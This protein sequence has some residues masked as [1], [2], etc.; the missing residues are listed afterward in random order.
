MTGEDHRLTAPL[1]NS[2]LVT[3]QEWPVAAGRA[4]QDGWLPGAEGGASLLV[5]SSP[6]AG[7]EAA[8]GPLQQPLQRNLDSGPLCA[9]A[10]AGHVTTHV[11]TTR[12]LRLPSAG[13]PRGPQR[14]W[15][16]Q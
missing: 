9:L 10:H 5:S 15:I 4:G 3:R 13:S 6:L 11:C 1:I 16:Q 12:V 14:L 7:L 2:D 8:H